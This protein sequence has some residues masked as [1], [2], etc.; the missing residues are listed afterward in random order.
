MHIHTPS[1]GNRTAFLSWRQHRLTT[2]RCLLGRKTRMVL[3]VLDVSEILPS[4]EARRWY[5]NCCTMVG[6][7]Q[8]GPSNTESLS[9]NPL[10]MVFQAPWMCSIGA[11]YGRLAESGKWPHPSL[12]SGAFPPLT[13]PQ[14]LLEAPGAALPCHV[15][16][17]H[18]QGTAHPRLHNQPDSCTWARGTDVTDV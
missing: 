6:E 16:N 3:L 12:R 10:L 7:I 4:S 5:P 11:A 9:P 8:L 15:S 13:Q 2:V 14:S 1:S 17:L 18:M